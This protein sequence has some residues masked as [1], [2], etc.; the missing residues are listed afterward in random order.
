MR[1]DPNRGR[2]PGSNDYATTPFDR[3]LTLLR[4]RAPR[5]RQAFGRACGMCGRAFQPGETVTYKAGGLYQ[6]KSPPCNL[7]PE[8]RAILE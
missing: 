4:L 6:C 3:A 7:S 2:L 5:A 1:D 8:A